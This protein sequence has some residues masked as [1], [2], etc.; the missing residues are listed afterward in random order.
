MKRR[1]GLESDLEPIRQRK[2]TGDD[3]GRERLK[4]GILSDGRAQLNDVVELR[5]GHICLHGVPMV[6]VSAP[7]DASR[8][9]AA[10]IT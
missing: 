9:P 2:N 1:C 7:R 4:R 3:R 6:D 10:A 8:K 5:D